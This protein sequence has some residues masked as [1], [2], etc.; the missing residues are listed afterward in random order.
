MDGLK[1]CIWCKKTDQ[2]VSFDTA[3]HTIPKALGGKNICQNVCDG[4]NFHF[5]NRGSSLPAIETVIKETFNISRMMYLETMNEVG[6]NKSMPKFSSLYFKVN[7]KSKKISLK[8]DFRKRPGFQYG[9][10]TQMK[11]GIYKIYLEESQRQFENALN[12]KF[13]FI[14]EFCRYGIGDY[15]VFYFTKQIGI[16]PMLDDWAKSPSL[17][18]ASDEKMKYLISTDSFDEFEFLGHTLG[19]ATKRNWQ[20]QYHHYLRESS[21]KKK[22]LFKEIRRIEKFSDFDLTLSILDD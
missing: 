10:G 5:G 11:K 12:P 2:E 16:I 19:V 1:T 14:R 9:L 3:A 8:S 6:K 13:D 17:Q 4:C 15:P 20:A 21:A 7:S 18:L 22:S